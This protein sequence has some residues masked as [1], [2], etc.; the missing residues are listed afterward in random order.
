MAS[1][2]DSAEEKNLVQRENKRTHLTSLCKQPVR[3][4]TAKADENAKAVPEDCY[5]QRLVALLHSGGRSTPNNSP[6]QS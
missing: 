3:F 5:L 4:E 6:T 2:A 1:V